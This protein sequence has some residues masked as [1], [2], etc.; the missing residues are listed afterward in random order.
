MFSI[1]SNFL[2]LLRVNE[3]LVVSAWTEIVCH[4]YNK[5]MEWINVDWRSTMG[6]ANLKQKQKN[7]RW[8]KRFTLNKLKK[9]QL[10]DLTF[11]CWDRTTRIK[12]NAQWAM[13]IQEEW[14]DVKDFN[15]DCFW[16]RIILSYFCN[17]LGWIMLLRRL[18]S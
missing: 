8:N 12:W 6:L 5:H 4:A 9:A 7:I 1:D 16:I 14:I 15:D 18:Q 17:F 11:K 13:G 10:F 2:F 3:Y